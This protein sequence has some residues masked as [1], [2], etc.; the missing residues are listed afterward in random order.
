MKDLKQSLTPW[1]ALQL[2][3]LLIF[4]GLEQQA[5]DTNFKVTM[6]GEGW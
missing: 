2:I 6:D 3:H 5:M 1:L 4:L